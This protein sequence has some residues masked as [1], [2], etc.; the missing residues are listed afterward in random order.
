MGNASLDG[1]EGNLGNLRNLVNLRILVIL[2]S[3]FPILPILPIVPI[4]S[5]LLKFSKLTRS[6]LL[7]YLIRP[8]YPI[9]SPY[10]LC[11]SAVEI[12]VY[13]LQHLLVI[14]ADVSTQA[15]VVERAQRLN[16]AVYHGWTKD[17]TALH[18]ANSPFLQH[19]NDFQTFFADNLTTK[20]S[21]LSL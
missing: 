10:L 6:A 4:V 17:A 8:I 18:F 2:I 9:L 19:A 11:L 3:K 20:S 12:L 5:A 14:R 15:T 1:R 21:H 13:K 7:I 16:N